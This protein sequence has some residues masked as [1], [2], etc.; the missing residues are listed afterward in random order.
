MT[1]SLNSL[2]NT[3]PNQEIAEI[4]LNALKISKEKIFI[5]KQFEETI[6][7]SINQIQ[8]HI[9]RLNV[10]IEKT[11]NFDVELYNEKRY[12]SKRKVEK[13]ISHTKISKQ[14]KIIKEPSPA[15][16]TLHLNAELY[17]FCKKIEEGVLIGCEN[18]DCPTKWFHLK[19]VG[20]S[21]APQGSWYCRNCEVNS[22]NRK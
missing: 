1:D 13:K 11:Q 22:K 18:D 20:M 8:V 3:L 9:D 19:C 15:P 4:K 16:E 21:E 5:A 10:E 7:Q 12:I 14:K 2:R 17:C 6:E